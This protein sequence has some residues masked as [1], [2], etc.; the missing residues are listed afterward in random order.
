L[1]KRLELN[2]NQ[3]LNHIVIMRRRGLITVDRVDGITP[4]YTALKV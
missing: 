4:I 1:S 2:T 3:V